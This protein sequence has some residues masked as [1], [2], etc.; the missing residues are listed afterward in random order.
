MGRAENKMAD[1]LDVDVDESFEADDDEVQKLK[2]T[3]TKRKG[4]GFQ[5]EQ[6]SRKPETYDSFDDGSESG[7]ARSVEGWILFITNVH[8][9]AQ[10]DDLHELFA[11]HGEIKNLHVN[12]DRRT[13]FLK[14]YSLVEYETF[15]EAQAA[16]EALNGTD[17]LGQKISVDWAFVRGPGKGKSRNPR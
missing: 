14:G 4:R 3:V 12:L 1:V 7:P 16:L 10:E 2:S 17:L 8:E 6:A 15:K 11:E 13:G 5:A 9:E